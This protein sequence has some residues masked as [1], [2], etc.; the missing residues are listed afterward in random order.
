MTAGRCRPARPWSP[1]ISGPA[2]VIGW[3]LVA[4]NGGQ[5]WVQALGDIVAAVVVVGLVGP[6][7]ALR[8]AEAEIVAAPADA[9]SGSPLALEVRLTG[10]ARIT[11]LRPTGEATPAGLLVVT[12]TR[13]ILTSVD[14]EISTS[15]PF[16]LQSWRRRATLALPQPVHVAPRLGRPATLPPVPAGD[17]RSDGGSGGAAMSTGDLRAA[18]PYQPG[19]ARRLIHWP[20]TSHCGELMV[21]DLE[22]PRHRPVELA[23]ELPADEA[24]AE[25]RA[26]QAL[27]EVL[28]LLDRDGP[29]L[30]VTR[31]AEGARR[32]LVHSRR[33]AM[34][35]LAAAQ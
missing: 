8:G 13:G 22:Q 7:L 9:V 24:E 14:V 23:V 35:R 25:R 18:R 20:S 12:P 33:E 26:G 10:T 15:A 21:R 34:R 29:V 28:A 6:W 32:G 31:E 4:R 30:L 27:A 11:A 5:G 19:D 2:I 17:E 3:W 16:G 1:L